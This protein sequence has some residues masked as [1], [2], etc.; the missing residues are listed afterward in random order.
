M[1]S[2]MNRQKPVMVLEYPKSCHS[3]AS[4]QNPMRYLLR[5]RRHRS[6]SSPAACGNRSSNG[7]SWAAYAFI[8]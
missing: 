5:S 6:T 7:N 3:F 8:P 2:L 4:A 1:N